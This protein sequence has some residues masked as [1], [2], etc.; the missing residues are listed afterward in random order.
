MRLSLCLSAL[1]SAAPHQ[2]HSLSPPLLPVLPLSRAS[3]PV[4]FYISYVVLLI[5]NPT[6]TASSCLSASQKPLSPVLICRLAGCFGR[7]GIIRTTVTAGGNR[8][9]PSEA[10]RLYRHTSNPQP[11]NKQEA[12]MSPCVHNISALIDSMCPHHVNLNELL[13]RRRCN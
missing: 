13:I 10:V 2:P 3:R 4:Y 5:R 9:T 6:Y 7:V 11:S 12:C 1:I 8:A